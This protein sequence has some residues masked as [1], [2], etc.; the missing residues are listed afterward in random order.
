MFIDKSE[1]SK[2]IKRLE[3]KGCDTLVKFLKEECGTEIC[4]VY[5]VSNVLSWA[6]WLK[7]DV[8]D[9]L[10]GNDVDPSDTNIDKV[11]ECLNVNAM[12]DDM[13]QAGWDHIWRAIE[14]SGL[15]KQE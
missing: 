4:D 14:K 11:I 1:I 2:A 3:H 10:E 7:G 8:A 6:I 5:N 13:I 15:T 9:A 12:E